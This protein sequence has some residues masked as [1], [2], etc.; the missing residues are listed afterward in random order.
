M[1]TEGF[2][3]YLKAMGTSGRG[4]VGQGLIDFR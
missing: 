4:L 3:Y 1:G 2:A